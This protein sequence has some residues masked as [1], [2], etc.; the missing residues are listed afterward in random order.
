MAFETITALNVTDQRAYGE[1]RKG[2][3]PILQR[4]GGGFRYDFVIGETLKSEAPHPITRVFA[5]YFPD[6]TTKEKFFSDPEYKKVRARFY[7]KSVAGRTVI[8]EY[9]R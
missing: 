3:S 6:R 8:A 5:I 1:Y 2:M 4:Y 7:E 9:D